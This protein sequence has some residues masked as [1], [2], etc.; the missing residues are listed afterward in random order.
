M[1]NRVF[2]TSEL[3]IEKELEIINHDTEVAYQQT[4]GNMFILSSGQLLV[5]SMFNRYEMPSTPVSQLLIGM[6][7]LPPLANL[8]QVLGE[9]LANKSTESK[10][11]ILTKLDRMEFVSRLVKALNSSEAIK[12]LEYFIED[13]GI[14]SMYTE[15]L[16]RIHNDL[17]SIYF[18]EENT[19]I[20]KNKKLKNKTIYDCYSPVVQIFQGKR[21]CKNPKK[22][23]MV[24]QYFEILEMS[25]LED[26]EF[27]ALPYVL[28]FKGGR[29]PLKKDIIV[30]SISYELSTFIVSDG[31]FNSTVVRTDSGWSI[32]K[33]GVWNE[34][35]L[36]YRG[37]LQLVL[38]SRKINK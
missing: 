32:F 16:R 2:F 37:E 18:F 31:C 35:S 28:A 27:T 21:K 13:D 19:W 5:P 23:I 6:L 34:S 12:E 22:D 4:N 38:Y 9:K 11:Q 15:I 25:Q 17:T 14:A 30:D 36:D 33:D 3:T 10:N 24:N 8:L 29:Y 26:A 7:H 1:N 20:D